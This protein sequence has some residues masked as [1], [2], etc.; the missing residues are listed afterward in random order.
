MKNLLMISAAMLLAAISFAVEWPQDTLQRCILSR[1]AACTQKAIE[2]G[3]D[4]NYFTRGGDMLPLMHLA[5]AQ[6]DEK[7]LRL[8]LDNGAD[9]NIRDRYRRTALLHFGMGYIVPFNMLEFLLQNCADPDARDYD[10]RTPLMTA[11]YMRDDERTAALFLEYV[12]DENLLARDRDGDTALDYTRRTCFGNNKCQNSD[13]IAKLIKEEL[14]KAAAGNRKTKA[15]R[16]A[17]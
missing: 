3:A 12:S 6:S 7:I 10:G 8:L 2:K 5:A 9:I 17:Y 1:D 16:K 4:V 15:C 11:V 13:K 14:K